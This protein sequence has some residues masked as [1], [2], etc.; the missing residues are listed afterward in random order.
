MLAYAVA[1]LG[2]NL[3]LGYSGQ[4]S[5]GH[6]AFFA[7][8]AYATAILVAKSGWPHLATLPV[9]A[10][11]CFAA[12][13]ALGIPALRLHGLYLA[14]VTLGLAVGDAAADQALRRAHRRHAGAERAAPP[15]PG[16][17]ELPGRRPVAVPAG[18]AIAIADVRARRR[19]RA[20]RASAARWSPSAT[21]RSRPRP[22]AST[23]PP[24]RRAPSRSARRT[25]A[26]AGSMFTIAVGFVA[27]ESFGFA[28][29]FSFL[30][31]IVV[32]GLG[33]RRR[34]DLRRAVHRV[35]AGLRRRRQRGA[36]GV[37]Y[38]GVLIIVHVRAADGSGR[39]GCAAS[40]RSAEDRKEESMRWLSIVALLGAGAA[41]E[42]VRAGR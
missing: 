6:G 26:S 15:V 20:R 42:R 2:L 40:A 32:G 19:D 17:R 29:S 30:A 8:G 21:T 33:D 4:I 34:R 27:P 38:G 7:L 18:L 39:P 36:R 14:L 5:L 22:S 12:G 11:V 41:G 13:F 16:W 31:A 28:L 23:S 37:I 9:A 25:P 24:T 3:L 10:A 35:R 1:A